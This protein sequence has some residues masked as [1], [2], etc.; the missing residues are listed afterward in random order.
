MIP[1]IEEV[2]AAVAKDYGLEPAELRLRPRQDV[3]ARSLALWL[4]VRLTTRSRVEIAAAL[5]VRIDLVRDS[6]ARTDRELEQ[7]EALRRRVV[8]IA[9]AL[10]MVV[11]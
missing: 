4:A 9:A 10:G 6:V 11:S 8:R 1:S 2:I 3:E 5:G 7:S